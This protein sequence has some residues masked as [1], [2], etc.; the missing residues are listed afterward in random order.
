MLFLK[1]DVDA[2]E[3]RKCSFLLPGTVLTTKAQ[4]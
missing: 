1:V 4:S 3:V 2:L